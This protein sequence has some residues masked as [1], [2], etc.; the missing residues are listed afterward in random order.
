M[1]NKK[2]SIDEEVAKLSEKTIILYTWCIPHLDVSG[3]IFA[4]PNI[5][6]GVVVPYLK[7]F[8]L[9]VIEKCL[10]ELSKTSLVLIYGDEHKYMQFLGFNQNQT[11]NEHKEAE[12]VIHDPTPEQLQ[13]NSRVTPRKVKLSKVNT[14][15]VNLTDEEFITSLKENAAFRGLDVSRELAKMD[16]W[17]TAHPGR[18]KTRRFIVNWLNKIDRPLQEGVYEQAKATRGDV[19]ITR[20]QK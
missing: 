17:L 8:S 1:L 3:K 19:P 14:R 11:I 4:N 9:K 16:A 5:L 20:R 15:T 2:I 18:Q 7:M 13:S 6:K 12:S 10:D